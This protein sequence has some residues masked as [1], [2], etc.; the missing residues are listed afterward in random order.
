M[1]QLAQGASTMIARRNFL[2]LSGQFVAL[3]VGS[4][5]LPQASWAK[6]VEKF[7]TIKAEFDAYVS[8]GKLPGVLAAIGN[9]GASP[10]VIAVGTIAQGSQTLC[11]ACIQ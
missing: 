5:F 2:R 6:A 4:S 11:G 3:G 8:S 9:G 7:P 1:N 10:D